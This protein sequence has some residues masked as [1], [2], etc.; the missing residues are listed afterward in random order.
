MHLKGDEMK[1]IK[2]KWKSCDE[3]NERSCV[4]RGKESKWEI[5]EVSGRKELKWNG[6]GSKWQEISQN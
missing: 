5:T 1:R 3:G 4:L 2:R 6:D